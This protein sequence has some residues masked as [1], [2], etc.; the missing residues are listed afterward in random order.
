[1]KCLVCKSSLNNFFNLGKL[2]PSDYFAPTKAAAKNS[3]LFKLSVGRCKNCTL[4]Q[5][6]HLVSANT[7]YKKLEYSYNSANSNYAKN[8]W[9]E[10]TNSLFRILKKNIRLLDIGCN[11]GYLLNLIQKRTKSKFIFGLDASPFQIKQSKKKYKKINFLCGFA[12]KSGKIFKKNY[13]DIITF[14]NV[15]N[16]SSN[17]LKFLNEIR[18]IL[19]EN[20]FIVIEVPDWIKT[21]KNKMWDQI[22]HEHTTYFTPHTISQILNKTGFEI[23]NIENIDYHGG[24]LR[25]LAK[26]NSQKLNNKRKYQNLTLK[27]CKTLKNQAEKMKKKA[28]K[29]IKL[30]KDSPIY[31]FGAPAK[32]NT[33]IN[34]FELNNK[35][36]TACL[37][38]SKNKIGKFMP[39]SCVPIIAEN[40]IMKEDGYIINLSWNIPFVFKNF[41]NKVGLKIIEI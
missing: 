25:V 13:F 31:L 30:I 29:K 14:N 26:K 3:P 32:G 10:F 34:Y 17:P 18:K 9:T 23:I 37:E 35:N 8:H 41:C 11:D 4:V 6:Q 40:K 5:N 1:M 12:E 36:I 22:Y 7:R 24:S 27:Q 2:P 33:L 15:F 21:V 20:G 38:T 39:K 28:I 19:R 16:H